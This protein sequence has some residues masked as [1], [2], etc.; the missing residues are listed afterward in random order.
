MNWFSLLL[1]AFATWQVIEIW[2]HSSLFAEQRAR[3]EL[4]N[5]YFSN[6]LLCPWCFSVWIGFCF[7]GLVLASELT[8][9]N[10]W[11]FPAFA[12]SVSRFANIGNDVF[13][14]RCRTPRLTWNKSNDRNDEPL[15]F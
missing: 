7:A 3:L 5:N 14:H 2:H 6:L 1:A 11:L 9:N 8:Q 12:F 10:L 4:Y 15:P 13:H